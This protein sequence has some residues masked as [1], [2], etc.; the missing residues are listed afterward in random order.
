MCMAERLVWPHF[1]LS[2]GPGHCGAVKRSIHP[3]QRWLG[4]RADSGTSVQVLPLLLVTPSPA[5]APW[6]GVGCRSAGMLSWD[7][8]HDP[9]PVC[10]HK[11]RALCWLLGGRWRGAILNECGLQRNRSCWVVI[12]SQPC[13]SL[14]L[15][16]EAFVWVSLQQDLCWVGGPFK[17]AWVMQA[18]AVGRRKRLWISGSL[19]WGRDADG[20]KAR[21]KRALDPPWSLLLTRHE[22]QLSLLAWAEGKADGSQVPLMVTA[23]A[24]SVSGGSSSPLEC[25]G[26]LCLKT[27]P[28][29]RAIKCQDERDWL[30]GPAESRRGCNAVH[31]LSLQKGFLFCMLNMQIFNGV[32]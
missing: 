32:Y 10:H 13:F 15:T 20:G 18:E 26:N 6:Q 5:A 30:E 7:S 1:L 23:R 25:L 3:W 29:S 27:H 22:V 2:P 9:I 24:L 12:G 8:Q 11:H 14:S 4:D 21:L 17:G 28:H 16:N 19:V 31:S